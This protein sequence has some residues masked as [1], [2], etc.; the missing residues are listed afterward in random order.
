M[1][2]VRAVAV[3]LGAESGRVLV[4]SLT[5]GRVVAHEV[6]RFPNV[7]VRLPEALYWDVLRIFGEVRHGLRLAASAGGLASVGVDTWG[8]DFALLDGKGRLLANPVH[9]RDERTARGM[10]EVARRLAPEEIYAT[11]GIQDMPVNTL[12]QMAALVGD[13]LLEAAESMLLM[14]DLINYWMCG[15]QAAERTFA[16]TT[17]MYDASKREWAWPVIDGMGFPRRLFQEL[18]DPGQS[19]GPVTPDLLAGTGL[20]VA[21]IDN[22]TVASHDTASAVVA[23]PADDENIAY[24]SSGTWSLVGVELDA[25]VITEETREMNFTNEEGFGA[26]TRF[27]K[28]VMGLWL[29]QECRRTWEERGERHTYDELV[30]QAEL[31]PPFERLV[32]PDD[33]RFLPPGDMPARINGFLEETDQPPATDAGEVVRCVLE[34]LA[35]K[36]RVVLDRAEHLSGRSIERIHI[37]GGGARNRVLNQMV[38]D[39]TDRPVVAGPTE[40]TG[41]GNLLVQMYAAGRVSSLEEMRTVARASTE[42]TTAVPAADRGGWESAARRFMYLLPRRPRL[43]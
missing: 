34:S 26:T 25:P 39:A 10:D 42:V 12:N 9:Y 40:A 35:L 16:S 36:Y 14:P 8:V 43:N 27:L 32:D 38:A 4:G 37:V 22:V 17:Q 33:N 3:D 30:A 41:L 31:A 6:H 11:T 23:V 15:R 18:V 1:N 19:L 21:A 29:L 5:E 13:P 7:P 20:D 2:D 28:N 24:I